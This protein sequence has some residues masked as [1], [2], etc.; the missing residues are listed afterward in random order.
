MNSSVAKLACIALIA[1]AVLIGG[2]DGQTTEYR[3]DRVGCSTVVPARERQE[4]DGRGFCNEHSQGI[5]Q[6]E[7][8]LDAP[9]IWLFGSIGAGPQEV[10]SV[11]DSK[12]ARL[13]VLRAGVGLAP[14]DLRAIICAP[15]W[16]WPCWWAE[17]VVACES[18]FQVGVV[19]GPKRG[20]ELSDDI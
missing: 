15:E 3:G 12:R 19:N 18:T 9:A 5:R 1:M 6:A 14:P 2:H 11:D 7:G 16:S 8:R 20:K 17:A 10:A 13:G 4:D